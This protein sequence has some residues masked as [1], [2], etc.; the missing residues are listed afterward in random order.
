MED[1]KL[2]LAIFIAFSLSIFSNQSE[3]RIR[4][5]KVKEAPRVCQLL[6]EDKLLSRNEKKVLSTEK[7]SL[8]FDENISLVRDKGEKICSWRTSEFD[9]LGSLDKFN[10]FI[11]EYKEQLYSYVQKPD[12][13]YLVIRTPLATCS[14]ENT[15]TLAELSLP[16]CEKPK[17]TSK[18]KKKK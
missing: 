11:D 15:L 14:L 5:R 8:V 17:K 16:K 3:A 7:H 6:K 18:K 4:L 9:S 13:S 1:M 10:F 2:Y 12:L